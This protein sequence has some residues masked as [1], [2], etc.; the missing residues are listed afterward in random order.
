MCYP[1]MQSP[2]YECAGM[3]DITNRSGY[4]KP[5]PENLWKFFDDYHFSER[6]MAGYWEKDCPV[7]CS[8]L[9]VKASVY[10]GKRD[11]VVAVANWDSN[12][13][14]TSVVIDWKKMKAE[15]SG[16]SPYIPE[17]KDF[18]NEQAAVSINNLTLPGGEGNLIVIETK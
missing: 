4:A 8:N 11:V 7:T 1:L 13:A 2:R 17:I 5:G 14:T 3:Q 16:L 18:Q 10:Q 15:P 9:R 6:K 12:D